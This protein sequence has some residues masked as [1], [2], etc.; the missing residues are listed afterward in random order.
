MVKMGG[1]KQSKKK[2]EFSTH[3]G[4]R[5]SGD[6]GRNVRIRL[7]AMSVIIAK[8]WVS[9]MKVMQ[10]VKNECPN[11]ENGVCR[12]IGLKIGKLDEK[13]NR[14]EGKNVIAG[15]EKECSIEKGQRCE[16]FE[17]LIE[18][19]KEYTVNKDRLMAINEYVTEYKIN[20]KE[21]KNKCM[22]CDEL[23]P[24]GKRYCE[25]CRKKVNNERMKNLMRKNRK[26]NDLTVII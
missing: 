6:S 17:E 23:I 3:G 26:R 18:P 14:R 25:I 8:G 20:G 5:L 2:I 22:R 7:T 16:Y 15:N 21:I 9:G 12:N 11:F 19:M 1:W 4:S 13:R 24:K 10:L